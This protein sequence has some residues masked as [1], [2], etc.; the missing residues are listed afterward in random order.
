VL[1]YARESTNRVK[2]SVIKEFFFEI[3]IV[4]VRKGSYRTSNIVKDTEN[5]KSGKKRKNSKNL[6]ND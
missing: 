1:S 2:K 3:V 5:L 6:V 4:L